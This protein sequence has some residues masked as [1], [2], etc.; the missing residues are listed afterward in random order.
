VVN[1][2]RDRPVT[3]AIQLADRAVAGVRAC[4]VNAAHPG[5]TNSFDHPDAVKVEERSVAGDGSGFEYT[6]PAHSITI[7]RIEVA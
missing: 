3:A 6:F 1:R 4:E 7:L 2:D 5:A